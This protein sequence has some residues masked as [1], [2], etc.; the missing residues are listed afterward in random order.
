MWF[1]W[2]CDDSIGMINSHFLL[3]IRYHTAVYDLHGFR[4]GVIAIECLILLCRMNAYII[5]GIATDVPKEDFCGIVPFI[6][7]LCCLPL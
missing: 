2:V 6:I 3:S 7:A 5:K 1:I 4:A